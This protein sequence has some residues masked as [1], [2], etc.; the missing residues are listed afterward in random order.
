M[1]GIVWVTGLN[2]VNAWVNVVVLPLQSV[3]G[4]H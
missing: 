3:R 1:S 4:S 2:S